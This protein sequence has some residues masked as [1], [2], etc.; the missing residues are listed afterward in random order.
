VIEAKAALVG[1]RKI[2]TIIVPVF[3]AVIEAQY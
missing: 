3:F 2:H 1:A